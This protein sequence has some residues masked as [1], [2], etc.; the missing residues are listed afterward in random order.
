MG[1]KKS[2]KQLE[3]IDVLPKDA[4]PIVEAARIYKEYLRE[5]QAAL[6]EEVKHKK[7]VLDLIKKAEL[8]PLKDG[9]IRFTCD[10]V[11]ISITPRDELVKVKESE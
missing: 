2:G 5:R 7:I 1:K 9:V 11:T 10:G 3:L 4:R 8:Q 6:A